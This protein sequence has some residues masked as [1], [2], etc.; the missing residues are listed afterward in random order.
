M[1]VFTSFES[2]SRLECHHPVRRNPSIS[3]VIDNAAANVA[4]QYWI[5]TLSQLS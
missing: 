4:E 1:L 3:A 2:M 5:V